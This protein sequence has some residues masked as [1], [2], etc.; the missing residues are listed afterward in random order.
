MLYLTCK[1]NSLNYNQRIGAGIAYLLPSSLKRKF[2]GWK[3]SGK[4]VNWKG[5]RAACNCIE[6]K[7]LLATTTM[8]KTC[9]TLPP[10]FTHGFRSN[11]QVFPT[12]FTRTLRISHLPK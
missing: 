7:L 2:Q 5:K 10:T 1:A 12:D 3:I 6:R 8:A 9:P 11:K 4:E